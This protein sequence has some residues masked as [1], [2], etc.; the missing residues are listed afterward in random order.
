MSFLW[1][2]EPLYSSHKNKTRATLLTTLSRLKIFQCRHTIPRIS[3]TRSYR[4]LWR[5]KKGGERDKNKIEDSPHRYPP[6]FTSVNPSH[7]SKKFQTVNPWGESNRNE[8]SNRSIKSFLRNVWLA[9][10]KGIKTIDSCLFGLD[11]LAMFGRRSPCSAVLVIHRERRRRDHVMRIAIR[12]EN[13]LRL[14][15]FGREMVGGH[16]GGGVGVRA[17]PWNIL[18][19]NERFGLQSC[20]ARERRFAR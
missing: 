3:S 12:F 11:R 1:K 5:R 17:R 4:I 13:V 2:R 15:S 20:T 18:I 10:A 8:G 7:R 14:A 16:R 19:A 6:F 9:V